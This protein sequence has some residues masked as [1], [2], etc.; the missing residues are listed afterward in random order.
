M[1]SQFLRAGAC[2]AACIDQAFFPLVRRLARYA[3]GCFQPVP[4]DVAALLEAAAAAGAPDRLWLAPASRPRWLPAR[5]AAL[6]FRFPAPLPCHGAPAH[7]RLLVVDERAAWC[8]ILPGFLTG[9]FGSGYGLFLRAHARAVVGQGLNA[10]LLAPPYHLERTP[11]G[12]NSGT[13]LITAD[14][15]RFALAI[16]GWVAETAA[17][18]A[19]LR[20]EY[21]T[22]AGL[23]G[24]SLGGLCA[25]L[26]AVARGDWAYAVLHEPLGDLAAALWQVPAAADLRAELGAH[27]LDRAA[28]ARM[29]APLTPAYLT[30]RLAPGR[31]LFIIPAWDRIVPAASQ[32]AWWE[33]WGR[34]ARVDLPTGHL[35]GAAHR[36]ALQAAAGWARRH[37]AAGPDQ[38]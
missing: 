25:G 37:A 13:A 21:G 6:R 26:A 33:A 24:C 7:G 2:L 5:A 12:Q 4:A 8:I 27:G 22:A 28:C 23:W 35:L 29:L 38:P 10:A 1:W 32:A 36:R 16:A 31:M 30:P 19:W 3:P 34:P 9:L 20:A 14:L 15:G 11:A 17:L 18:A